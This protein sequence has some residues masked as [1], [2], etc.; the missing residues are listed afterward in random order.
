[1]S[2]DRKEEAKMSDTMHYRSLVETAAGIRSRE[3]S[4]V[5]LTEALLER[6]E[7]IDAGLHSYTNVTTDR[8]LEDARRAE[9]E[10]T[11]GRYRG[12]LHGVPI[13]IKD[14]CCTKGVPTTFGTMIYKDFVPD[15]DATVVARLRAAGAVTLGMLHLHEGAF[16]EHHPD[17]PRPLNPWNADYWPGG[18]SSGSGVATAAGLCFGS[19]GTD[20][21]GSIRFPSNANGVTGL[22]PTWGR[23]SRYG[24]F[25]LS[26]SLDTVGPMARTAADAA[27]IL[28]A[29]AGYDANDPT[30]LPADVPDYLGALRGIEGARGL[31]IGIDWDY[32]GGDT[33]PE[34]V[35]LL[36]DALACF[37]DLGAEIREISVPEMQ[38]VTDGQL[39]IMQVQ[40]ASFH[41]AAFRTKAN[42]FGPLL[43]DA[44]EAGLSTP[45]SVYAR[46][47][48]ERDKFKGRLAE[49][50]RDVDAILIPVMPKIGIR[51]DH[52]EDFMDALT[53]NLRF[54]SPFNMAGSPS[55]TMPGGFSSGGLPV[56]FQLVGPHLSESRLLSAAHAYQQAT[57]WHLCHPPIH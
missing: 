57:D 16:A 32:V 46:H 36:R 18:S 13:A 27:A 45:P 25:P 49:T 10:I 43:R 7:A 20:T 52:F 55:V 11:A 37:A 24:V 29:I 4:P 51:Y 33:D 26:E 56:G 6:I 14:L 12:P 50:F 53:D 38:T 8:A 54:T 44:I 1:L 2:I 9:D 42:L 47:L 39:A 48:I 35:A 17:L 22:K 3:L 30:S 31:R 28:S 5:A 41:E 15:Y 23:V 40:C 21:G 34:I 19:L